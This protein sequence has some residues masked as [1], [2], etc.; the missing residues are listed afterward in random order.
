MAGLH[1]QVQ[2]LAGDS[3]SA[4]DSPMTVGDADQAAVVGR[5]GIVPWQESRPIGVPHHPGLG[6]PMGSRLPYPE[7]TSF[8][9]IFQ[10]V[11][12]RPLSDPRK[13]L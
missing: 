13:G 12:P 8:H 6:S 10:S 4:V 9:I 5:V 7:I 11:G 2:C 3:G 1:G